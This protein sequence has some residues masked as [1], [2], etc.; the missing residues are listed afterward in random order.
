MI[1]RAVNAKGVLV[2]IVLAVV[3]NLGFFIQPIT[4]QTVEQPEPAAKVPDALIYP[5]AGPNRHMLVVEKEAQRIY[6]YEYVDGRYY[7]RHDFPCTTGRNAGAKTYQGDHRTPEGYFIFR[8]KTPGRALG[9]AYGILAYPTDYPNYWDMRMGRNGGSILMHGTNRSL[10]YRL[11]GGCIRLNNQDILTFSKF[12][13][14]YDTPFIIYE[15]VVYEDVAD[16]QKKADKY[17]KF[18]MDWWRAWEG[19]DLA[20]YKAAYAEGFRY[21]G[22]Q[23]AVVWASVK[24]PSGD[25]YPGFKADMGSLRIFRHREV[26][27]AVFDQYRVNGTNI[28]M[29]GVKRLYMQ[30]KDGKPFI[31]GEYRRPT[32][33]YALPKTLSAEVKARVLAGSGAAPVPVLTAARTEE[34]AKKK[35]IP[36]AEIKV[37]SAKTVPLGSESEE[38]VTETAQAT[39]EAKTSEAPSYESPVRPGRPVWIINAMAT[40][41]A[42]EAAAMAETLKYLN[43]PVYTISG[44]WKRRQWH[45]VRVGFFASRREATN[46]GREL[47]EKHH[48]TS[49]WIQQAEPWEIDRYDRTD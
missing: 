1:D 25:F 16:I 34:P 30:E 5:G 36:L 49:M 8:Y 20:K 12:V 26:I 6:H 29:D 9:A 19:R 11:S 46:M 37:A 21:P 43:N 24:N 23:R 17:I 44:R 35:E 22:G 38:T 47:A 27:V 41:R 2:S 33:S 45:A 42:G 28:V 40:R 32:P 18:V 7:L 14:V 10:G 48:L 31:V 13:Q 39:P 15:K 4:A 3:F